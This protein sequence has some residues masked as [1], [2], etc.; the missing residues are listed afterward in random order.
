MR[1]GKLHLGRWL[2]NTAGTAALLF[3]AAAVALWVR[4]H[5]AT[6]W[7]W[8][9][10]GG[11]TA[12]IMAARDEHEV[13]WEQVGEALGI[14]RQAAHERFR[15]GPDGM[16]SR[17]FMNKAVQRSTTTSGVGRSGPGAMKRGT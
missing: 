10:H 3:A 7:V 15:T 8:V 5:W 6:D 16:H 1:R 9:A 12:E 4:S 11:V 17:L 13:T 2:F 14:S